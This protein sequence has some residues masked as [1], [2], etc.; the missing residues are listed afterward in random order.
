[1]D[2]KTCFMCGQNSATLHLTSDCRDG[3]SDLGIGH[4]IC[5]HFWFQED[6]LQSATICDPCWDKV[7][8]FH[9]YYQEVKQ[10]HEQLLE[11]NAIFIKQEETEF[12]AEEI[13]LFGGG[14]DLQL[15]DG[16]LSGKD[17]KV[18]VEEAATQSAIED[19]HVDENSTTPK[20]A[21]KPSLTEQRR[22][23]DAFIN[24]HR[25]YN[26][27]ECPEKFKI[28][29]SI[30]RHVST[31]HGQSSIKCCNIRFSSRCFL[32]QHVQAVINPDAFKCEICGKSY[33]FHER[34]IRHK[35]Q[36]HPT[37]DQLIFKCDR[38]PKSFTSRSLLKRHIARHTML[39]N[40]EAKCDVCG[41]CFRSKISLRDHKDAIHEKKAN[42]ICEI[43]SK[44]FLKHQVFLEHRQTHDFTEGQLKRQCPICKKWQKNH[45]NWKKH[46]D[47]HERAG[48]YKCDQC[49]HVSVNANA[50]KQHVERRHR[51]QKLA[52]DLCGKEY[53]GAVT[54]KEHIANAHT[55]QPLYQCSFCD[56]SFFS[57]ASMYAHRKKA[58]P[59]E[60]QECTKAKYGNKEA[61]E[62]VEE[63]LG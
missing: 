42:Y 57:N 21:K 45:R 1:M 13:E 11:S 28:F 14:I 5:Q 19:D 36:V 8:Q 40:E 56:R 47:R 43:C 16:T 60:W 48:S 32:L 6:V 44:P 7:D 33:P 38:C 52:C 12:E 31:A 58:H 29:S 53:S 10:Y 51:R 3:S 35:L 59:K 62:G 50:L 4:I 55:G 41:K 15:D 24:Q 46:M 30:L 49:D 27:D 54:L 63:Y 20:K 17:S 9:R 26:C 23:E 61:G 22:Q 18:E 25:S 37:E 39:E 2:S 34:Y